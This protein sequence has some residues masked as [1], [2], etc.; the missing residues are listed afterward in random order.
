MHASKSRV[1]LEKKDGR[2]VCMDEGLTGETASPV[3]GERSRFRKS[4]RTC[5]PGWGKLALELIYRTVA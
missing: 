1:A 2:D 5:L 3:R 4:Y